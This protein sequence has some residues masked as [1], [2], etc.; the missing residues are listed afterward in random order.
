MNS[1][2]EL[3]VIIVD[4]EKSWLRSL[5]LALKSE[6][7]TEIIS[8]TSSDELN[9]LL[10][11]TVPSVIVLDLT[12]AEESGESI[13]D[14]LLKAHPGLP[15]IITTGDSLATTAVRCLKSGAFNYFVKSEESQRIIAGIKH[16]IEIRMLQLENQQLREGMLSNALRNPAH[17]E[18][19]LLNSAKMLP[20]YKYIE[21]VSLSSEPVLITG[22][23]GTGKELIAH[24]IHKA[25]GRSGKFIPVNIAGLDS[26]IFSDTLFGHIKGAFTGANE[27]RK[28][29]VEEA[30]G[31]TL[32][33]DEIGDLPNEMQV[34]LLRLIQEKTYHQ[35]GSDMVKKASIRI[36]AATNRDLELMQK[37]ETFRQDLYYRLCY[38]RVEIPP[39]RERQGDIKQ[40]ADIFIEEAAKD[41]GMERPAIPPE[42]YILLKNY[43][44][45]GNVRELRSIIFD[46]ISRHK[47]KVFSLGWLKERL[48]PDSP[49]EL[50]SL[51]QTDKGENIFE[52]VQELPR[53][54]DALQMLVDE[55]MR[56]SSSNQVVASKMIGMNRQTLNKHLQ[57][58]QED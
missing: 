32:F 31:G 22:E 52:G 48:F 19:L 2:S 13:L 3:P 17:F 29:L 7:I 14:S 42:I 36:I 20:V 33:L 30:S 18:G 40:L 50:S 39:L 53:W 4:D 28:G 41:I 6:G 24:A 8:C 34:K 15:V 35:V 44:Y 21:A 1:R 55:A 56:R 37:E 47:N 46:A 45:P 5:E 12:L 25:S 11:N 26:N 10:L 27:F 23:S 16:A 38:H 58:R 49:E 57:S 43:P 9:Q 54:K 51:Q